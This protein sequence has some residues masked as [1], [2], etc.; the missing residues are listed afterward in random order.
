[1]KSK[2]HVKLIKII[3]FTSYLV[4][5]KTGF[6]LQSEFFNFESI[7]IRNE[8]WTFSFVRVHFIQ[9]SSIWDDTLSRSNPI[10][11]IAFHYDAISLLKDCKHFPSL[12][13]MKYRTLLFQSN[14]TMN[15][16]NSRNWLNRVLF[17]WSTISECSRYNYYTSRFG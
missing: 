7:L 2:Y 5:K 6:R 4:D 14:K 13:F 16:I 15:G 17:N 10:P 1:M 8:L 9:C 11:W 3:S 12:R